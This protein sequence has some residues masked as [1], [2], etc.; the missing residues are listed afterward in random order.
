MKTVPAWFTMDEAGSWN[1]RMARE[2]LERDWTLDLRAMAR[3]DSEIAIRY[4]PLVTN[5]LR[6]TLA[7][8]RMTR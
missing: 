7:S 1:E 6:L 5:A 2:R 3:I 8:R 4:M